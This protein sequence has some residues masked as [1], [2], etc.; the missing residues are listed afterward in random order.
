VHRK[1]KKISNVVKSFTFPELTYSRV[2]ENAFGIVSSV[3]RCL[4]KPLLLQP[5]MAEI[6]VM[7][8]VHLHNFLRKSAASKKHLLSTRDF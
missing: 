8:I 2:V 3:F 1:N 4:R 6:I 5:E 7:A